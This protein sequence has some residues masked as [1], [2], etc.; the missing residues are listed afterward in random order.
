MLRL[1]LFAAIIGLQRPAP[2]PSKVG[3]P[4]QQRSSAPK[5]TPATVERGTEQSPLVVKLLVP[6]E[7]SQETKENSTNSEKAANDRHIVWLTAA[8]VL[9]AFLQLL[10]YF[11]QSMKLRETV[12]SAKEQSSAMERHITEASRSAGAMEKVVEVINYGNHAALRAYLTVL[13]GGAVYQERRDYG[14]DLKFEAK[15][16]VMNTGSTP[17]RKVSIRS[18]A[19]VLPMPIPL[20]FTYPIPDGAPQDAGVIGAHQA[21]TTSA[22]VK[23]LVAWDDVL[24]IKKGDG[25]VL[26]T[27]GI[28]SYEDIFGGKHETK[29][30]QIIT[31]QPNGNVLGYYIFGQNDAS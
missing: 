9:I 6:E 7:A 30:G 20:D 5:Q 26:C 24:S 31:W 28:I 11:Y 23:D 14:D 18:V 22:I 13:I 1:L 29:F 8:L 25:K 19:D 15:P 17:A 3:K 4:E 2:T 10:V 12:E 21:A 16:I 27:W